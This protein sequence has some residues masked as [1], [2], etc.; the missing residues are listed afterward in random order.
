M[1]YLVNLMLVIALLP[2][3]PSIA[4]L[5]CYIHTLIPRLIWM[6]ACKWLTFKSVNIHYSLEKGGVCLEIYESVTDMFY[7]FPQMND[8]IF[9]ESYRTFKYSLTSF[10]SM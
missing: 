3:I 7:I 8:L 9:H 5:T 4:T 1:P 10:R 6:S 2:W